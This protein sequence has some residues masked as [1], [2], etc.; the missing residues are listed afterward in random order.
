MPS[1]TNSLPVSLFVLF[2]LGAKLGGGARSRAV[3]RIQWTLVEVAQQSGGELDLIFVS[4]PNPPAIGLSFNLIFD[5]L[6]IQIIP[7]D[8]G[9]GLFRNVA[10]QS[11]TTSSPGSAGVSP[12]SSCQDHAGETPALPASQIGRASCRGRG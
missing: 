4:N 6:Y 12:A 1:F 3:L 10:D 8:S 7:E 5:A 11:H 2:G 9:G